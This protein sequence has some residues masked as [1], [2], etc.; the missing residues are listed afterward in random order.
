[1][2][3]LRTRKYK[4]FTLIEVL[5]V[6]SIIV[7]LLLIAFTLYPYWSARAKAEADKTASAIS[8]W[9]ECVNFYK[10]L[11]GVYPDTL[12][13]AQSVGQCLCTSLSNLSYNNDSNGVYFCYTKSLNGISDL[14]FIKILTNEVNGY[15]N[16]SCPATSSTTLSVGQTA[17]LTVWLSR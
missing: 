8:C 5:V 14:S 13:E 16:T 7:S 11:R 1:M 17:Y 2:R 3:G 9:V 4:G 15:L 12:D 6:L 10:T